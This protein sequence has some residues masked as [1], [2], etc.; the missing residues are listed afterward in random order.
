MATPNKCP[1]CDASSAKQT[2]VTSHVFGSEIGSPRAFFHCLECDVRY[3]F[4]RLTDEEEAHFYAAEFEKFMESRSGVVGGWQKAES[5]IVANED[6]RIRRMKKISDVLP[7]S[8]NILEV[9]CS[10]G[11]M[12]YPLLSE[13]FKCI[14]VEPS[15]VFGEFVREKGIDVY[16][17]LS[18]LGDEFDAKFD[19]I[20]HFF[21]L[22][23]IVNPKEFLLEQLRLLKPGGSIVFEVPNAADPLFS[24]FDLPAFERFYWSIAHPWYFSEDSLSFLLNQLGHPYRLIRD[25]RYDLSNHFVWAMDGKPGGMGLFSEFFGKELDAH[26]KERLIATGNCDT[27]FGIVTKASNSV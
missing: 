24:I 3:Q 5:H 15:N 4:P 22:E 27:L 19:V 16:E 12:L 2:V 14:G 7:S 20:M 21:V 11:F 26:Y 8:G 10:S 1:L 25:Q 17:S 18:Q 6:T 23:H 13:G 9:G